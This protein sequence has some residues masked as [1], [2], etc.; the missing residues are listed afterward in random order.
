MG[1]LSIIVLIG[2]GVLAVGMLFPWLVRGRAIQDRETCMNNLRELSAFAATFQIPE[3]KLRGARRVTAIPSGTLFHPEYPPAERLSWVPAALPFLNQK[4][5]SME[6]LLIQ[7]NPAKP[8]A[9]PAHER[10]A[11]TPIVSLLCPAAGEPPR[12]GPAISHYGASGGLG[13]EGPGLPMDDPRAGAFRADVP[14]PL[15]FIAQRDGLSRTLLFF[16][17]A[18][19]APWI[20]GGPATLWSTPTEGAVIGPGRPFGGNHP[21]GMNATFADGRGQF[22][23]ERVSPAVFRAMVTIA[24]GA[25]EL[26]PDD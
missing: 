11:Q 25:D 8:W 5:Q 19:S 6:P 12:A 17:S 18:K 1:R 9:D 14:T 2:L 13:L 26:R 15:E 24:G 7:V 23:S 20:A 21:G 10:L 22:I 4:R 3:E 16:E